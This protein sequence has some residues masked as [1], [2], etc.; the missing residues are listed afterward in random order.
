MH[1]REH[2][3]HAHKSWAKYGHKFPHSRISERTADGPIICVFVEHFLRR[4][5]RAILMQANLFGCPD[6]KLEDER[7]QNDEWNKPKH[8]NRGAPAILQNQECS[9]RHHDRARY[10]NA[11]LG[12]AQGH[13]TPLEK[14]VGKDRVVGQRSD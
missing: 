4:A 13:T 3:T 8:A 2:G 7:Q 1:R 5:R 6:C 12:Y 9:N 14:P 10:R 11:K